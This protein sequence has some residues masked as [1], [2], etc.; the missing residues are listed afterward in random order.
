MT[1]VDYLGACEIDGSSA[2]EICSKVTQEGRCQV[3]SDNCKHPVQPDDGCCPV[4]GKFELNI[5]MYVYCLPTNFDSFFLLLFLKLL[6]RRSSVH[7]YRP[8]SF[9]GYL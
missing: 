6:H 4:C 7:C 3:N 8:R 1:R 5:S 9:D 2:E